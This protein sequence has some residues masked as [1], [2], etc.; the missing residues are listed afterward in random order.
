M[1]PSSFVLSLPMPLWHFV[2]CGDE[3]KESNLIPYF[4]LQPPPPPFQRK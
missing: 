3:L 1:T 2:F 4:N